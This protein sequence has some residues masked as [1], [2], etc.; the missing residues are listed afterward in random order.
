[1]CTHPLP[2]SYSIQLVNWASHKGLLSHIRK[3]VFIEEQ[4]VP[5]E[6]E[7]D[8]QDDSARHILASFQHQQQFI[9]IGCARIIFDNDI[10]HIGRMAVLPQWRKQGAGQKILQYA[11]HECRIRQIKKIVLNAQTH[12]LNF[13]LKAGFEISSDEFMDAGIPHKEMTYTFPPG[14]HGLRE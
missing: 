10:A 11:I 7:W 6:L 5:Q 8:G 3:T 2:D 4:K 1:M 12:V 13:Y 9:T 14:K